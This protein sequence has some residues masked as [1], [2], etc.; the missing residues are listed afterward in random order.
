[1]TRKWIAAATCGSGAAALGLLGVV[2][3]VLGVGRVGVVVA[4]EPPSEID[5]LERVEHKH[6]DHVYVLPGASLSGY[7]RIRLDPVDVSFDENWD[8]NSGERSPQRRLSPSDIE[9]IRSTVA[10]EFGQT[11]T[12]ELQ[13][14]G[15][16][17]VSED[18]PDVLRV[19]PMIVNLYVTAPDRPTAGR[20]RTY[21]ANSGHMTLVIALR[22]SVS[23]QFLAR[24]VDTQQGRDTGRFQ[25]ANS[26][27][28][29]G[30][31]RIAFSKWAQVLREGLA[32]TN[33]H[34][35]SAK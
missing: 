18:A 34:V 22:D 27:T 29:L 17:L 25:I 16:T 9:N 6:L 7:R 5:G 31:A 21:V 35:A 1:M 15:Y 20:S 28:N 24:A 13:D 14:A 26:V 8:P 23:G 12:K 4:A 33:A 3:M 10:T 2:A 19:T 30:D 11:L 32:D